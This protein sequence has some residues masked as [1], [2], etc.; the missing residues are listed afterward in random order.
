MVFIEA[1]V[2]GIFFSIS[3]SIAFFFECSHRMEGLYRAGVFIIFP[4]IEPDI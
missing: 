2:D 1:A 3:I 4:R